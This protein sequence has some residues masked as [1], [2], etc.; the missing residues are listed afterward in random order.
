MNKKK[1]FEDALKRLNEIVIELENGDIILDDMVRLYEEGSD[2]IKYCLSKLDDVEKKISLLSG[3]SAE[4]L[5]TE[6]FEE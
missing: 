6:T 3:D 4:N 1:T 5:K 2:N